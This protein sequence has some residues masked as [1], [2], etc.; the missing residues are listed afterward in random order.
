MPRAVLALADWLTAARITP[1]AR[2]RT[3][4]SWQ[5]VDNRRE[6]AFAV[7][8]VHAP[9]VNNVPGRQTDKAAAR[10]FAKRL[11]FGLRPARCL[12]PQGQR[13]WR[14]LTRDRTQLVHARGRAVNRVQGV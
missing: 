1:V 5:P 4:A 11:R 12:P 2:A 13:A 3:G 9:P 10:G 14:D 6:D 8:G 7:F